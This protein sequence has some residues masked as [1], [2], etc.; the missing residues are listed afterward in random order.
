M[1]ETEGDVLDAV[2]WGLPT[3]A[4]DCLAERLSSTWERFRPCFKTRTR[5]AS[6]HAWV[7]LR[8][9]LTM[10]NDRTFTNIARRVVDPTNDGQ[11]LQQFMSDSPWSARAVI[12]QV[13]AELKATPA[14][15]TEGVLILDE[16][17][18]EKAGGKSAGAGRQ[19]NGRLGIID[20][21]Q[22]GTFLAFATESVWTWVDG[23][24]FLPQEWFNPDNPQMQQRRQQLG[25]PSDREFATKVQLG[26]RMIER[27]AQSGL[28]FEA[29]L[30][31]DLYGRSAWLR[32]KLDEAGL[33]YMV[34]VP[35]TLHVYLAQPK[36]GLPPPELVRHG[37]APKNLRVVNGV[38]PIKVRDVARLTD[39]HFQRIKG[40]VRNIE[41]GVLDDP[42]AMRRVWT[43]REGVV[44]Q[45]WLVM[46]QEK[47][48]G[49]KGPI[50]FYALSNAPPDTEPHRLA[51]LKCMRYFIER[52]NQDAKSE[53][54]WG[55]LQAQ[56]YL[57]W[58]HHLALTVLATWF[59]A[60]TKLDWSTQH[61]R[62]PALARQLELE[63]LPALSVANV[64]S[65]LK[66][67]M[68]L[69]QLSREQAV[70]VVVK[71]LVNRS[72]STRS[73]LNAQRRSRGPT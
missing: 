15:S 56:K 61:P 19:H 8:G 50:Y 63:V 64:R 11:G 37:P 71:H 18:D 9:L 30:C 60:Q 55:E 5:D 53:V 47:G 46:R 49:D 26:W 29:V 58:E 73:R 68:P 17:A 45:E 14:L 12:G 6:T 66:A 69:P 23:E 72:R 41:R 52:A 1:S 28:P 13:Q 44:A 3:E 7:Y 31:D 24:L 33:L 36:V 25:I 2:R 40:G 38:V 62:D 34:D 4:V 20:M 57:A 16:S 59:I 42:F 32:R 51:W 39:T 65:M 54:G 43:V 10:D 48:Q 67:V 70:G 35:A 22:V 21:C 27:V